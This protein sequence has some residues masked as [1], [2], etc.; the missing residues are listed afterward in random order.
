M[1]GAG[2]KPV[3]KRRGGPRNDFQRDAVVY[4]AVVDSALDAVIVVDEEGR[5]VTMNASAE[6]TFGYSKSEAIGRSIGDLD[7]ARPP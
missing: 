5:V 1:G 4:A 3:G 6:T 7:R 2:K